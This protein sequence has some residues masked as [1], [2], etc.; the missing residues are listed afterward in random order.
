MRLVRTELAQT[1]NDGRRSFRIQP[2]S[3]F[4]LEADW[5]IPALG[6]D[7]LPCLHTDD[8]SELNVN[9]WGGIIVDANQMTSLPGVF[10]GG[11]L[12]RG[13]TPVLHAVRDARQAAAQIHAYLTSRRQVPSV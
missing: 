13:P 4:E 1:N 12:V 9:A 5:V 3:E 8:F 2:G 10:A 7:P 11:D 6:F